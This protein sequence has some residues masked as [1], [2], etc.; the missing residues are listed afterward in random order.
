MV[1]GMND[2][3]LLKIPVFF[4]P[5]KLDKLSR[6]TCANK[7]GQCIFLSIGITGGNIKRL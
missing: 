2:Y 4:T 6:R 7:E 1:I 3:V 5:L